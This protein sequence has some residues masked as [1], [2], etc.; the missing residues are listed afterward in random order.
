VD[1]TALVLSHLVVAGDSFKGYEVS[2]SLSSA[3]PF[4]AERPMYFN[5]SG[6]QGGDIQ[7]GYSGD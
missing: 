2:M 3:C 6:Y 5:A 7:L 4:V 1:I